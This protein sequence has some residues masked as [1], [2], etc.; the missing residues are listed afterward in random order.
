MKRFLT[1]CAAVLMLVVLCCIPAFA[2][3]SEGY[4]LAEMDADIALPSWDDYY[5]LYPDMPEDSLDLEYLGMTAQE[6]NDILVPDDILLAVLYYDY[7]HEIDVQVSQDELSAELFNFGELSTLEREIA[8]A[9]YSTML[10]GSGYVL[11]RSGWGHS[12]DAEWLV[13]EYTMPDYDW[14]CQYITV[15]NGKML[16]LTAVVGD[17][18]KLAETREIARNTVAMM[19]TETK[20]HVIEETPE[21]VGGITGNV[22]QGA[23]DEVGMSSVD[24][25]DMGLGTLDLGSLDFSNL[26]L[27]ALVD[28]AGLTTEEAVM[29]VRGE[30]DPSQLDL[31]KADPKAMADALGLDEDALA[32]MAL[33]AVGVDK[34]AL[35][36]TLLN[37]GRSALTGFA[38]GILGILVLIV[39]FSVIGSVVRKKQAAASEE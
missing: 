27:D 22:I 26:D 9:A 35:T 28:A 37:I 29:L 4:Y 34:A 25:S 31:S 33:S 38:V 7:T 6:I 32:D 15:C 24:L 10:E 8:L 20:F 14:Y 13:L 30:L 5:F 2:A 19:A 21:G 23:L 3:D 1:G 39:V 12:H 16:T 11:G 17:S 18:E 36:G